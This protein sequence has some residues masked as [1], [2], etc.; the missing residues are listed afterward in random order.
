MPSPAAIAADQ[1]VALVV[2][3]DASGIDAWPLVAVA[4][5]AAPVAEQLAR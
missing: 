1:I 5:L 4:V 3:G 2:D